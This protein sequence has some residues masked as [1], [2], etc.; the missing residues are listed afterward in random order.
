[1]QERKI[2]EMIQL[3]HNF[4]QKDLVCST[5][6]N[7][8]VRS[9]ESIYITPTGVSLEGINKD[10]LIKLNLRGEIISDGKPSQEYQ[11][12]LRLYQMNSHC[13][14]VVHVH[15][16]YIIATSC[17]SKPNTIMPVYTPSYASR[18]G[19]LKILPFYF[20]GTEELNNAVGEEARKSE[21][22]ILMNHGL[23]VWG[24]D[25]EKVRYVVEEIV[26]NAKIFVFTQGK[27]KSL[28]EEEVNKI[29]NQDY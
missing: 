16:P 21:S 13:Q 7:I 6:G 19:Y 18:V 8:S 1:M 9:D 14:I 15:S 20:P 29:K 26:E 5:G 4:Y 2:R 22:V 17:M 28:S 3:C 27:G 12:H 23:V 10:N 24:K 25:F 11:M